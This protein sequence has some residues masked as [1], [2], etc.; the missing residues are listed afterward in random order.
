MHVI[1]YILFS[2]SEE[3]I[4]SSVNDERVTNM[5]KVSTLGNL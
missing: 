3:K 2:F 1:S 5:C 4:N